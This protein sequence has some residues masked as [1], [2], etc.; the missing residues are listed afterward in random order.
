M[1]EKRDAST[2]ED[3]RIHLPFI[4]VST[5]DTTTIQLEM[6]TPDRYVHCCCTRCPSGD[7]PC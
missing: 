7:T 6:D 3:C 5:K 1:N 2:A 4:I